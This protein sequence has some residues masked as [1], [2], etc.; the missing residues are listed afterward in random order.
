MTPRQV[1]F[2]LIAVLIAFV[3]GAR[4]WIAYQFNQLS[5]P[6]QIL[7]AWATALT[8]TGFLAWAL[9]PFFKHLI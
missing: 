9:Y 6:Q 4:E 2:A 1:A 3:I 5:E 8:V 7:T